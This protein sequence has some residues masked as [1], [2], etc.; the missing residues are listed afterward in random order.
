MEP[1]LNIE[2]EEQGLSIEAVALVPNIVGQELNNEVEEQGLSMMGLMSQKF[3]NFELL[4][5]GCQNIFLLLIR[6]GNI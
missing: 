1:E 6:S 2:V 3:G 5:F 4:F